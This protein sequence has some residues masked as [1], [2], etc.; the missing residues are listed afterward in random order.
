V[1]RGRRAVL[2]SV[3]VTAAAVL[4]LLLPRVLGTSWR[5]L[6]V[7]VCLWFAG[8]LCCTGVLTSQLPG[9]SRSQALQLNLTGNAIANVARFGGLAGVGLNFAMVRSWKFSAA[10]LAT[11][12]AVRNR[13]NWSGKL[14]L[15]TAVLGSLLLRHGLPPGTVLTGLR[16]ALSLVAGVLLLAAV[17]LAREATTVGLGR[18]LDRVVWLRPRA[19][20][21]GPPTLRRATVQVLRAR[22]ASLSLP[23]LGYL[24]LQAVLLA[25]CLD[26]AEH[27]TTLVPLTPGG[28]GLADTA[29][30]GVLVALGGAPVMVAAAVLLYRGFTF[31]LEIPVGGVGIVGWLLPR[32]RVRAA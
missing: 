3:L 16:I 6:D 32:D 26:A 12:T 21:T 8:L 5:Y 9:L 23:M 30:A 29:C 31:L 24:A 10:S 17:V 18:F 7:L 15:A 27:F 20:V 28:A 1:R 25:A 11:F 19:L 4:V 22:R 13:W 2:P 14:V